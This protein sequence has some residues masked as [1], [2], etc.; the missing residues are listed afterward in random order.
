MDLIKNVLCKKAVKIS[1]I[2]L[3]SVLA[4]LIILELGSVAVSIFAVPWSP[5]YERED[6]LN[7]L[8][9]DISAQ[10]Y[11]KLYRQTGL[12]RIGIDDLIADGRRARILQIQDSFFKTDDYASDLFSFFVCAYDS[13]D[14]TPY[15]YPKLRDGDIVC[16]FST[17]FSF[18]EM[19]H[20]GIVIDGERGILAE[21]AGYSTKLELV[22]AEKFFTCTSYVV[23]RPKCDEQT[24]AA[25]ARYVEENMLGATYD[26]LAGVFEKKDRE[27]LRATQCAHAIWYAYYKVGVDIDSNGGKIVTPYDIYLSDELDIVAVRGV[28]IF[29]AYR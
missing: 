28:D 29:D 17:Y 24:R 7:L 8:D 4:V 3:L 15:A 19:G 26:I 27:P 12:T 21:S 2:I 23:L 5:D 14:G 13:A 16:C 9:D 20:C 18:I 11:D 25:A 22:N 6:I 1:A 10:E